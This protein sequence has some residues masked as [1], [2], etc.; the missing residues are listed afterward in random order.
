MKAESQLAAM[1]KEMKMKTEQAEKDVCFPNKKVPA[2][3]KILS[4][5]L[6][7]ALKA[8]EQA[9]LQRMK[10]QAKF[11][12][13]MERRKSMEDQLRAQVSTCIYCGQLAINYPMY[14]QFYR[15]PLKKTSLLKPL[16]INSYWLK[17]ERLR[18]QKRN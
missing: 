14:M 8:Q 16:V 2:L 3:F 4:D 13:E 15:L 10:D 9:E 11:H 12:E 7:A 17:Y 18:I 6:Q 5:I 1:E